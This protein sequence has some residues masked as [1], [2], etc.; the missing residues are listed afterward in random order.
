MEKI[1]AYYLPP[2]ELYANKW[3]VYVNKERMAH[4]TEDAVPAATVTAP[5]VIFAYRGVRQYSLYRRATSIWRY[6]V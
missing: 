2:G 6:H 1:N 3:I 5:T 4:T